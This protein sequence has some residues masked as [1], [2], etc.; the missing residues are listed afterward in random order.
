MR[1]EQR[2]HFKQ[3]RKIRVERVQLHVRFGLADQHHS[4]AQW[5]RR[6][7]EGG[8]RKRVESLTEIF[9]PQLALAQGALEQLARQQLVE[10]E[11]ALVRRRGHFWFER[12]AL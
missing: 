1:R 3:S 5:D 8:G 12:S 4:H 10:A 2:L 7:F 6:R 9:D 11:S